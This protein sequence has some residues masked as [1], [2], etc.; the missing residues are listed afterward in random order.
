MSAFPQQ[1]HET[2]SLII[3]SSQHSTGI[4]GG[5][6]LENGLIQD[7]QTPEQIALP[8][9]GVNSVFLIYK[10]LWCSNSKSQI[11]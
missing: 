3:D 6:I 9:A 7:L 10:M 5:P 2:N 11:N 4:I 8:A 1:I